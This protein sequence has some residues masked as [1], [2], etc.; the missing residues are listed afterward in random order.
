MVTIFEFYNGPSWVPLTKQTGEFFAPKTL[1][2]R[3]G[4]LNTMKKF[5]GIDK[6]PPALEK[7][8]K[9]ATKLIRELPTDLE[10]DIIPLK[11]LSSLTED[12]YVKTR[13]T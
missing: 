11:E 7:S 5:L 2:D 6:I 12:I 10:M 4:G 3:L 13:E 1:R 8:F 9:A